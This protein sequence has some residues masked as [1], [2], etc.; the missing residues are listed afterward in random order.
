MNHPFVMLLRRELWE[1]RS[2]WIAPLVWVGIL[3]IMSTWGTFQLTRDNDFG[4]F[5]S[6]TSIEELQDLSESD[7]REIE[8]AMALDSDRGQ[9]VFAVSYFMI[10]LLISGFMSIV[11]FFYLI[12]SLFSERRDRSILFWKSLPVSDTQVVL[13][14][15]VMA[16]LVVPI[17]VILLSAVTQLVLLGIW[18]LRFS[19]SVIGL[20]TPDWDMGSWFRAQVIEAGT[21]LG[22]VMWYAPIAAYFLLLSVWVKRLVFLW[23]VIPLVAAP[24]L[25]FLFLRTSHVAEFLGH[26]FGGFVDKMNIDPVTVRI[27]DHDNHMPRVQELY[28]AFQ[29][30]GMFT[31]LE[32]WVGMAA[33]AGLLF[34]AIRIRRYRDDS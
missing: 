22:G 7:R 5:A 8:K 29:L 13:S 18:N 17:G 11:V 10:S 4:E 1:H 21:M 12:D 19:N 26:R 14:K 27:G 32:T 30:S 24:L 3:V 6:A 28:D 31:S 20:M 34:L 25:E 2:L 15:F 9:T 16:M 23:A 33:A